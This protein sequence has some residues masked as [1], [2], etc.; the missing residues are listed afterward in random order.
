MVQE[1]D[2]GAVIK[3]TMKEIFNI[4]LLHMIIYTN[5]KSLYNYLVNL[6]NTQEK[7]FMVN[8]ICPQ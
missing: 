1:F 3:L 2:V 8:I 4:K 6:G 7:W 5:S